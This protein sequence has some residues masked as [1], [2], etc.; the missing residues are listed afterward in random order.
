MINRFVKFLLSMKFVIILLIVFAFSIGYATFIEND[1]GTDSAKALIYNTWWF[2]LLLII[3]AVSLILNMFKHKLFR[4]EKLPIL[5][6]HLSFILI[7]IGAG[8]TRYMSYEGM[9]SISEGQ[10]QNT[11]ISNDVFLQIKVN[12]KKNQF[13]LDKKLDLS[14]ITKRFDHTPILKNFFSKI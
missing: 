10:S 8:I 2:E 13:L 3:L 6:F 1:F 14:G 12:D 9:M 5:A 7:L 11:F 4:K